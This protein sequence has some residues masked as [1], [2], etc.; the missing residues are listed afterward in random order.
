MEPQA[1]A[2]DAERILAATVRVLSRTAPGPPKVSDIIAEAGT[3]NKAF[4]RHFAGKEDLMHAVLRRGIARVTLHLRQ[5]MEREPDP[6]GQLGRW[7]RGL[8]D[9]VTDPHLF[10]LCHATVAQVS[11]PDDEM[12]EPLREL[13]TAPLHRMGRVDA[14]RDA[15]A[16]FHCT[17]GTL[18]RYV[19]SGR[20]PPQDDIEHLVRFCLSGIG[21][22]VGEATLT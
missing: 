5:Q 4:Y 13:L 12:M 3:C 10:S 22:R 8:L 1:D 16:V 9:Q 19:G 15:D 20:R 17:M 21:V 14:G 11:A 18:R 7:V 2:E 6:A